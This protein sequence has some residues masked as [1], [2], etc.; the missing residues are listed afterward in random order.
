MGLNQTQIFCYFGKSLQFQQRI[1]PLS[2]QKFDMNVPN[3]FRNISKLTVNSS[4]RSS[5]ILASLRNYDD[6]TTTRY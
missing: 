1:L 3:K 2:P 5:K 4:A 6:N